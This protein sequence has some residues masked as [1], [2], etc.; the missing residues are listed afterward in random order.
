MEER[1]KLKN[2]S[3]TEKSDVTHVM[4]LSGLH[5]V[6]PQGLL[7]YMGQKHAPVNQYGLKRYVRSQRL[8]FVSRSG[9]K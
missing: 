6:I 8:L 1:K 4:L 9:H 7:P 3:Y 2:T 5:Y